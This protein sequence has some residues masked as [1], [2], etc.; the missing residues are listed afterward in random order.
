G[1]LG[2]AKTPTFPYNDLAKDYQ[3]KKDNI[4]YTPFGNTL[5]L[6]LAEASVEGEKLGGDAITDFL[7]INL[8][9]TDYAGHKFGPN[10]IE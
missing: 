5:T 10:S 9:S 4:R 7:A 2:S 6:K 1:L 8:A 3:T